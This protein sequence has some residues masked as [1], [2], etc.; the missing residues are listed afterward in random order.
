MWGTG[1]QELNAA[2]LCNERIKPDSSQMAAVMC[3]SFLERMAALTGGKSR[4]V[5]D[6]RVSLNSGFDE[7]LDIF[8]RNFVGQNKTTA[9]FD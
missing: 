1:K 3:L 9:I 7:N 6:H 2:G 8:S 5:P 4:Y